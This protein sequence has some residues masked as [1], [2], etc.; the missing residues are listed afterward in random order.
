MALIA[1]NNGTTFKPIPQGVH[2]GRCYRVI[3]LGT[4]EGEYKGK[5]K[6]SRKIMLAWELHGED[7][8][9][10]KLVNDEGKPL[11]ISKRYTLSLADKAALRSDLESWR[12]KAFT[13]AELGGFDVSVL[14]D[15]Y[16]LINVKHEV[17]GETTYSNVASISP[18]PK[19]M[20]EAKPIGILETQLFDVT[21]PDMKLFETFSDKL[22]E[23]INQCR[24]WTKPP[25]VNKAAANSGADSFADIE[26]DVVF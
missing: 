3:D 23:T 4:Q 2:I 8:E 18:L 19:A 15:A 11:V 16:A 24:E 14:I 17:N 22:K 7:E 25:S 6:I 13:P 5:K 9:G 12:G 1:Q 26:D 20:R 21:E 10:N